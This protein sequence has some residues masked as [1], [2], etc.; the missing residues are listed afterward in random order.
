MKKI[1]L[2]SILLSSISFG[3]V[4]G[5]GLIVIVF[6]VVV[7]L[8]VIYIMT[9]YYMLK[10][11]RLQLIKD[12]EK[13]FRKQLGEVF[14]LYLMQFV[15]FAI[16]KTLTYGDYS[17]LSESAEHQKELFLYLSLFLTYVLSIYIYWKN[18]MKEENIFRILKYKIGLLLILVFLMVGVS[19]IIT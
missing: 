13:L 15:F 6:T 3:C 16:Y 5:M 14:F 8:P 4:G 1:T 11:K 10:S 2:L 18:I 7:V 9:N 12:K 19:K 17:A